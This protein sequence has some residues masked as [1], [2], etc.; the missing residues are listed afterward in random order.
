MSPIRLLW[1]DNQSARETLPLAKM[2]AG[3]GSYTEQAES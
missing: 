3:G 2:V 1:V